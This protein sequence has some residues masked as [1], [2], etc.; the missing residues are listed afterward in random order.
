MKYICEFC[1][2]KTDRLFCFN[3][4]KNTKKHKD[5]VKE[6][7]KLSKMTHMNIIGDKADKIFKC[8][9]CDAEYTKACNLSRHN[10]TCNI[11]NQLI[12]SH[13]QEIQILIEQ[14]NNLKQL[15][16]KEEKHNASLTKENEYLKTIINNAGNIIK[17][18]VSAISYVSQ[19]YS[20]APVLEAI[21]DYS[22]LTYDID[23]ESNQTEPKEK[24]DEEI[25][26]DKDKF[27]NIIVIKHEKNI[28]DRY[29][30]DIIIK[31]YKKKDPKDQSL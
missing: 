24:T 30:G 27:I 11:K 20:D 15:L 12:E 22:K 1:N 29:L 8:Q 13:S 17:S 26:K 19:H 25:R 28:L 18:S 21:E 5:K 16:E 14:N 31:C 10:K 7:T 3:Q 6:Q 4:H 2:F 23:S 9:F